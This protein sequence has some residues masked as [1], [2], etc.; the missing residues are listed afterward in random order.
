MH[1]GRSLPGQASMTGIMQWS[2]LFFFD[3]GKAQGTGSE[4]SRFSGRDLR[5]ADFSRANL[6]STHCEDARFAHAILVAGGTDRPGSVRLRGRGC[7][8][9]GGVCNNPRV[10][11]LPPA[12]TP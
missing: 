4:W 9:A 5:D 12:T 10:L 8:P 1:V 6:I 3:S 7:S 2:C 11:N